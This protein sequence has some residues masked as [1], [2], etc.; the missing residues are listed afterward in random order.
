MWSAEWVNQ[1]GFGIVDV[2]ADSELHCNKSALQHY[3]K[4]SLSQKPGSQYFQNIQWATP[5]WMVC[6]WLQGSPFVPFP[7]K[8]LL[9]SLSS[10][11]L[12]GYS[13]LLTLMREGGQR[14]LSKYQ[15]PLR[16]LGPQRW[17]L[18]CRQ[19]G[20]SP[21]QW[22]S[23]GAQWQRGTG[24]MSGA[25]SWRSCSSQEWGTTPEVE[26]KLAEQQGS[27]ALVNAKEAELLSSKCSSVGHSG[28]D[29]NEQC[30]VCVC[31]YRA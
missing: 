5:R 24:K 29:W 7:S 8:G 14:R 15:Q 6:P 12:A 11:R 27:R 22:L 20:P 25:T 31:N 10:P 30:P 13:N 16:T 3:E 21:E 28:H 1:S 17:V 23:S 18:N 4:I 9:L 26:L 19:T 2:G